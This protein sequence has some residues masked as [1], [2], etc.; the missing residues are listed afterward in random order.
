MKKV[1]IG[2]AI[3]LI[4]WSAWAEA[5]IIE[6]IIARVNDE[7]I[8]LSEYNTELATL[9]LQIEKEIPPGK[10]REA[11]FEKRKAAA[12]DNLIQAKLLWHNANRLGFCSN[13]DV[14][15]SAYIERLKKEYGLN[16]EQFEEQIKKEG[17]TVQAFRENIGRNICTQRLISQFV[18][19]KIAIQTEE[20]ENF[21]KTNLAQFKKPAEIEVSEIVFL[22]EGKDAKEVVARVED[23]LKRLAAGEDFAESAKKYSD[24][25]TKNEGG[26]IGTFK[27]GM[28]APEV[29]KVAFALKEGEYSK[30]PIKTKY[31]FQILKVDKK[32]PETIIPLEDVRNR[33]QEVLYYQKLQPDLDKYVKKLKE[34]SYIYIHPDVAAGKLE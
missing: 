33:I 2:L 28:M 14:E 34:E 13:V 7:V 20:I 31:G 11:E 15:V 3:C 17:L 16:A 19:Q 23:L 4:G 27:P 22:T 9:R 8:T 5:K 1:M 6:R 25:P 24:G 29:E 30:E 10:E 26:R 32:R 18:T 12:L 21:Y